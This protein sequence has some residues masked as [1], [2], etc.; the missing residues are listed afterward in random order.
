[1]AINVFE[2]A[3]RIAKSAAAIW[4][5]G[6]I[7]AAFYVSPSIDVTYTLAE[8]VLAKRTNECPLDSAIQ[9]HDILT[10]SGTKASVKLCIVTSARGEL[11]KLAKEADKMGDR[12]A[13]SRAITMIEEL[14]FKKRAQLE[15]ALAKAD[16]AGNADDAYIIASEISRMRGKNAA[17]STSHRDDSGIS[18][19]EL[20]SPDGRK[21]EVTGPEGATKEQAL[22]YAEGQWHTYSGDIRG[23]FTI[24]KADESWIDDQWWPQLLRDLGPGAL[25]AATGLIFLWAFTFGTG[26][27]IRGFMG[28]PQGADQREVFSNTLASSRDKKV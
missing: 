27:V 2:G 15:A 16:A 20:T 12:D 14:D 7:I 5:V 17:I 21:F 19:F 24:P 9:Y 13:A 4:A 1:M 28:I 25:V 18:T 10:K 22:N 8:D 6:W 23:V 26:W 3:R 11:I